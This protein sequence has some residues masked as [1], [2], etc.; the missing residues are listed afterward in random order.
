MK[1]YHKQAIIGIL[2]AI[3]IS[4]ALISFSDSKNGIKRER[5]FNLSLTEQEINTVLR[6][7]AEL[8]LKESQPVYGVIMQQ[9]QAQLQPPKVAPV[10]KDSTKPKKQ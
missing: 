7:L 8:P 3:I 1:H 5:R 10:Q 4:M 6:G 2:G 9:A